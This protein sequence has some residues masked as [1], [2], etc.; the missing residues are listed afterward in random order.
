M[1]LSHEDSTHLQGAGFKEKVT[2][3]AH[4]RSSTLGE[5]SDYRSL[6]FQKGGQKTLA[7]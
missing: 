7:K 5:K 6:T 1:K 2:P 3:L 4:E